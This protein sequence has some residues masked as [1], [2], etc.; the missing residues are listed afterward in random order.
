MFIGVEKGTIG[1]EDK[2]RVVHLHSAD[3]DDVVEIEYEAVGIIY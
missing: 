3:I 2:S 1:Y